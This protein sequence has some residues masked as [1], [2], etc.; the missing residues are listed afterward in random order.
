MCLSSSSSRSLAASFSSNDLVML[1]M[2]ELA[3]FLIV[4]TCSSL[5]VPSLANFFSS[6]AFLASSSAT[7][8]SAPPAAPPPPPL[9][10]GAGGA[11]SSSSPG[12][13]SSGP[14]PSCWRIC[15]SF[16]CGFEASASSGL[17]SFGRFTCIYLSP[18]DNPDSVSERQPPGRRLSCTT[19]L[20]TLL[21][22]FS[23]PVPTST[24]AHW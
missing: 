2:R 16:D 8:F 24:P 22:E 21:Q 7:R 4:S 19:S 3:S 1:A 9:R 11:S 13:T 17:Y 14:R 10:A 12:P 6:S 15:S 23:M 20:G 5:R 18:P